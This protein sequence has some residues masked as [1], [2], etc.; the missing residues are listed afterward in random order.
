[1]LYPEKRVYTKRQQTS[2][3][4]PDDACCPK[5]IMMKSVLPRQGHMPYAHVR[6]SPKVRSLECVC[7]SKLFGTAK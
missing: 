7:V 4:T 6:E 5:L 3:V 1:M 2:S